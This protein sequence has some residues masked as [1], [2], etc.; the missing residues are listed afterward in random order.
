MVSSLQHTFD[1]EV[2]RAFFFFYIRKQL[3][4]I[5]PNDYTARSETLKASDSKLN[6]KK[7]TEKL[8]FA[9]STHRQASAP[10]PDRVCVAFSLAATLKIFA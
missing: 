6:W 1:T 2:D 3:K 9:S 7:K 8:F 5:K 10:T 4:N